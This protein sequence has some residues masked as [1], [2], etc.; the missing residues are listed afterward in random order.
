MA[1]MQCR[2]SRS[3]LTIQ[4]HQR[5]RVLAL[6]ARLAVGIVLDERHAITIGELDEPLPSF[7]R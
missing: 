6:I 5:R 7:E 1:A 3:Q 2:L 4:D